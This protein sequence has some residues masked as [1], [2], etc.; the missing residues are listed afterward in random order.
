MKRQIYSFWLGIGLALSTGV[1]NSCGG[2]ASGDGTATE[3]HSS[4]SHYFTQTQSVNIDVYYEPG[5]EPYFGNNSAARPLWD[6]LKD[7]LTE[8]FKYRGIRPSISVP[9]QLS[10]MYAIPAQDQVN[11]LATEILAMDTTQRQAVS[12]FT[13]SRFRIYFL[14]GYYNDG[15]GTQNGVIGVSINGT[16]I[17]AIFKDVIESS[18]GVL[19]VKKFVEQS[20]LVHEM[21][22]ALGFVNNGVP[23]SVPHQDTGRGAHSTDTDCV[24]YYQNEGAASLIS[25]FQRY[26][27]SSSLIMWG[28]RVLADAQ[29]FSR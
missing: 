11:W 21:G 29:A 27:A 22:H 10:E 1:L 7:N 2:Q 6:V 12:S 4:P 3:A 26:M 13:N 18:S 14:N 24:M 8:I 5:A 9:T 25:F 20:T 28:P 19:L 23:M 15:S 17:I 16:P